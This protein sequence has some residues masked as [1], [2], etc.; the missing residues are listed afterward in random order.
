MKDEDYKEIK[1]HLKGFSPNFRGKAIGGPK[2]GWDLS[3]ES[4]TIAVK[5]GRTRL[6]DKESVF[7]GPTVGEYRHQEGSWIW[8]PLEGATP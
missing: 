6:S 2:D 4:A 7:L 8:C 1:D 5:S 3:S